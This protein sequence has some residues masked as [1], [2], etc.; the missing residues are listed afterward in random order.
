[1]IAG[2][3]DKKV[4]NC[5]GELIK[6]ALHPYDK[7]CTVDHAVIMRRNNN[8]AINPTNFTV[9]MGIC[10]HTNV[11]A[12]PDTIAVIALSIKGCVGVILIVKKGRNALEL[13]VIRKVNIYSALNRE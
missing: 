9:T 6:V 2:C 12:N 7:G 3:M 1:M 13:S 4:L 8:I 11:L 5:G 10:V